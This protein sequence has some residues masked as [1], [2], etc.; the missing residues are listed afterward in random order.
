VGVLGV[1][2][3]SI[4][5][6]PTQ[7]I[8][9]SFMLPLSAAIALSV[10]LGVLLPQNVARS[11]KV[12]V[13]TY[14]VCTIVFALHAYALYAFRMPIIRIF[15]HETNVIDGCERIW[16][17][18][19]THFF[20]LSLFGVN[21]GIATG[22]GMQWTLGCVTF[23]FLWFVALP[24]A[25]YYGIH[26]HA[27]IDVVWTW[28]ILPYVFMNLVLWIAFVRQDWYRISNDIKAREGMGD[29]ECEMEPPPAAAAATRAISRSLLY[30]SNSERASLMTN[31]HG[32]GE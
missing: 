24:G 7:V 29:D 26:V 30:G 12:V 28:L 21:A 25:W 23:C 16:W 11:K 3:L 6:V 13:V 15:A 8:M 32:H 2:S 19:C 10:R 18:V 27:S 31:G 1:L 17:K 5:A 4:H 22:L 9:M 14:I 20:L